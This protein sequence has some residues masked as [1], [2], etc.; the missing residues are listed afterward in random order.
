MSTRNL[1][2]FWEAVAYGAVCIWALIK[3]YKAV[4]RIGDELNAI[5]RALNQRLPGRL[6]PGQGPPT[7]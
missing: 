1:I 5:S 7:R 4:M 3:F 6:E 2:D